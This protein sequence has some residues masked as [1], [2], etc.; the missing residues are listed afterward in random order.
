MKILKKYVAD[1]GMTFDSPVACADYEKAK[2]KRR[3]LVSKK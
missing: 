1:D 2:K 3:M